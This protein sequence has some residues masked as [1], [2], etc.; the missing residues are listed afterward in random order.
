MIDCN[1]I[2]HSFERYRMLFLKCNRL[3]KIT[4]YILYTKIYFQIAA[5]FSLN[6]YSPT[7]AYGTR[8]ALS[9]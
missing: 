6:Y 8:T 3:H 4:P 7:S 5:S 1:W 2:V 9:W